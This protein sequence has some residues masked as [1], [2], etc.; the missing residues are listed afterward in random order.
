MEKYI[1]CKS[2]GKE[3]S[4]KAN[5]CKHCG[6]KIKEVCSFC[7][8]R[9]KDNYTCKKSNCPGYRLF[10]LEKIEY[11]ELV[12]ELAEDIEYKKLDE[13]ETKNLEEML[14]EKAKKWKFEDLYR[15]LVDI[16]RYK[17]EE[18]H[19]ILTAEAIFNDL[20][21]AAQ[22][23][24]QE[25]VIVLIKKAKAQLLFKMDETADMAVNFLWNMFYCMGIDI[26]DAA[27]KMSEEQR[28]YS[29]N[30]K[31]ENKMLLEFIEELRKRQWDGEGE[32]TRLRRKEE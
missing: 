28:K 29:Y 32:V 4:E 8:V 26:K 9:K 20:P 11:D 17:R 2:C 24:A 22:Q 6:T 13:L 5:F 14:G 18:A 21:W 12:K 3:V 31:K 25:A 27:Q 19:R 16:K 15:L 30:D 23:A 7:W 1:K 10:L